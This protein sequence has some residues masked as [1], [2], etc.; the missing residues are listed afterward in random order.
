MQKKN[1]L[2]NKTHFSMP[3]QNDTTYQGA[4]HR[5]ACTDLLFWL[6]SSSVEKL[7]RLIHTH[8]KN[9]ALVTLRAAKAHRIHIYKNWI[10]DLSQVHSRKENAALLLV[11]CPFDAVLGAGRKKPHSFKEANAINTSIIEIKLIKM[12]MLCQKFASPPGK[13][14]KIHKDF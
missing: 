13:R 11:W 9:A 1:G 6:N 10:C 2:Y 4:H 7:M 5:V 8:S 14:A 3:H 12:H